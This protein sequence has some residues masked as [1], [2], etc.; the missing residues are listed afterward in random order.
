M[1]FCLSGVWH[2]CANGT[3]KDLTGSDGCSNLQ[4]VGRKEV[5]QVSMWFGD[6]S[7]LKLLWDSNGIAPHHIVHFE[8]QFFQDPRVGKPVDLPSAMGELAADAASDEV[9]QK[10]AAFFESVWG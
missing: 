9:L 10:I 8:G 3:T 1:Y 4:G 5:A 7:S 6:L 2:E